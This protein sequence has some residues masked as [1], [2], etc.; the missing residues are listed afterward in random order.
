MII[1][2]VI[3]AEVML[4]VVMIIVVKGQDGSLCINLPPCLSGREMDDKGEQISPP[5]RSKFTNIDRWVEQG[6]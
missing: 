1:I 6:Q 5:L 3:I 2:V 4:V